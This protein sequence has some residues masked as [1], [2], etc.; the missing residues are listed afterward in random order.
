ML[1]PKKI[2][3]KK[4]KKTFLSK[5]L[6][7]KEKP[8]SLIVKSPKKKAQ[9]PTQ[10]Q[11]SQFIVSLAEKKDI[12]Y[13]LIGDLAYADIKW[14]EKE[15][16]FVYN[17][18][19]P[20]FTPEEQKI[21]TKMVSGLM[22]ILDVELSAIKKKEEAQK[23]LQSQIKKVLEEYEI[24]ISEDTYTKILYFVQRNFVGLNEIEPLMQDPYIEDI[25]CDGIG[26]PIYIIHRKYGSIK[27][28]VSYNDAK[29]LRGF[30]V[31]LSEE[32]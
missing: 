28:N 21:Y 10:E 29:E 20:A 13:S 11:I 5:L 26:I 27:T 7:S 17:V 18:I 15:S 25:S 24:K 19:E 14:E 22:E 16:Q 30:V 1:M 2:K 31:K 8:K 23:Y 9:I 3:Q 6:K 12:K 32:P 4:T